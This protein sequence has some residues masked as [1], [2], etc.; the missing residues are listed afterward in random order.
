MGIKNT[1][2]YFTGK[3]CLR[4]HISLRR[5]CCRSCIACEA[6]WREANKDAR[7]K[8]H[9]RHYMANTE[10][11][12]KANISWNRKNRERL[13][14]QSAIWRASNRPRV[15]ALEAA[16]RSAKLLAVPKWADIGSI[17]NIYAEARRITDQTG[18]QHVV[19]HVIPLRGKNV[20]GLHVL[21][22]LRVIQATENSVKHNKLIDCEV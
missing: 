18:I 13:K 9:A 15:N 21:E 19:D 10:K 8:A 6:V 2:T 4:G 3:P 7:R 14:A 22:N 16:R 17:L 1:A 11:V 5:T 12:K 20:C